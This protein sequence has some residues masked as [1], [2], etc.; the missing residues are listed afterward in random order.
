M[1][2]FANLVEQISV[3]ALP[4]IFAVTLHEAAHGY[5][6]LMLGDDTAKREGRLSLN[7][8][9]HIDPVGTVLLPMVLLVLGGF[10]FGWAKPVPVNF[11][12]LRNP[13]FGMV[14]VAAAGPATNLLLAVAAVMLFHILPFVP[15]AGRGWLVF[16]LGNALTFNLLLAVFNM[17]PIP[18]LDGGRVAVGLLPRPLAIRLASLENVGM[19][20]ILAALFLLPMAG[21]AVG[22]DLDLF[23][24][25]MNGPVDA[26]ADVIIGLS[27]M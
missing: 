15:E 11:A 4:L 5:A 25:L 3:W 9:R 8:L 13:R 23:R 19:L 24:W 1:N 2:D 20:I 6:A 7:P 12:R 17:L 27:G 10:L 18:P 21:R 26:L 14:A 16:N 22:L